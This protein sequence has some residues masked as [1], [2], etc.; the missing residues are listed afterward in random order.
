L[1]YGDVGIFGS[2][3]I[4]TPRIDQLASSGVKFPQAY[5]SHPVCSPS[6]AGLMTGLNQVRHG[7]EFNP[8]G[9]DAEA[10]MDNGVQT[11]AERLRKQG[12]Y[13]A[14][15]GKWHLGKQK[16]HHP[17][18][19]G[20]DE[21]YG[22]LDG[23]SVFVDPNKPGVEGTALSEERIHF[24]MNNRYRNFDK[25]E[26]DDYLTDAFTDEAVRIIKRKKD[27]PFF[28]YLSHTTPHTPLQAT[29]KYLDAYRHIEDEG[30][31]VYSAMVGSL[32]VSVGKIVDTLKALKIFDN[33]MI[34][35]TSDNGC[36]EY[37]L[38]ACSNAPFRGFKRYHLE[39]GVRVPF[40]MHWP[41]GIKNSSH[42]YNSPVSTLD[43]SATFLAAAGGDGSTEDSVNLLPYING[44]KVGAPHKY[45]HWKAGPTVAVR[46]ERWKLLRMAPIA[47]DVSIKED[48]GGRLIPPEG[49]WPMDDNSP[50]DYF[51]YD[52]EKDSA[53]TSN[54]ITHYPTV[55][56]RLQ[57]EMNRWLL[58]VSDIQPILS[59]IRSIKMQNHRKDYQ[60]F[61]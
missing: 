56:N 59:P 49:G 4:S 32:D 19:R 17:L 57:K 24:G 55:A 38:G 11:I 47:S 53:E 8:A 34:V 48:I 52:L 9:R 29:K 36:A 13:N 2:K 12:Y 41:N 43:L 27:Q 61:F 18:S 15:V 46:D 30:T 21:F 16:S 37:I 60:L 50:V 35:F 6:R 42:E 14:I 51:L 26:I 23:G 39:G 3:M 7:W 44:I 31:R 5:V 58:E 40:V 45:L 10:G 1:G 22:V 28:L 33:T 20:F 25:V 54:V